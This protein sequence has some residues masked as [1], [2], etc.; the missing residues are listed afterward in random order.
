MCQAYIPWDCFFPT[1][2]YIL[3]EIAPDVYLYFVTGSTGSFIMFYRS[4]AETIYEYSDRR[5]S[6]FFVCREVT[7]VLF[8]MSLAKSDGMISFLCSSRFRLFTLPNSLQC[9]VSLF[10]NILFWGAGGGAGDRAQENY[11]RYIK[12]TPPAVYLYRLSQT[13]KAAGRRK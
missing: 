11:T 7:N 10:M 12:L 4:V 1:P 13:E 2:I 9:A 6:Y 5:D 3:V 8:L